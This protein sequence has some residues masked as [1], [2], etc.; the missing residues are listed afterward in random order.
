MP[1][2]LGSRSQQPGFKLNYEQKFSYK[3]FSYGIGCTKI[4][5]TWFTV[6]ICLGIVHEY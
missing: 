4:L 2:C 5:Y 1:S 6:L 3:I